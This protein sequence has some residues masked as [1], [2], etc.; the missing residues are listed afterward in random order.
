MCYVQAEHSFGPC[1]GVPMFLNP[2]E[3]LVAYLPLIHPPCVADY[4][5]RPLAS[6][7][8]FPPLVPLTVQQAVPH[9]GKYAAN[10]AFGILPVVPLLSK[11]LSK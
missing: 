2:P 7:S 8:K 4:C 1:S 5:S 3:T 6:Q 11:L 9:Y 10:P